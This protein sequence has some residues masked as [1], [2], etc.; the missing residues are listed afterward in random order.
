MYNL[1]MGKKVAELSNTLE[2]DELI[3]QLGF[4][5]DSVF[6]DSIRIHWPTIVC[7]PILL[8]TVK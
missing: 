2:T 4:T 1:R 5:L 8:K 7:R 6:E 3:L